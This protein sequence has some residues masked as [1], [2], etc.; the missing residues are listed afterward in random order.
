ME[1]LRSRQAALAAHPLF[2]R[3]DNLTDLRAF[4]EAHVF[5]VWDF[6]SLLKRLQ[7]DLTCVEVPWRPSRHPDELVRFINQIVVGEESDLGPDGEATSH[8][9]LYLEAMREVGANTARIQDFLADLDWSNVPDHVAPFTRHTLDVARHGTTL[10]VAAAF[11]YGREKLIPEMFQGIVNVLKA[12]GLAWP[13]L[14]FYLERHIQVDGEEHGP[15]AERCLEHLC[16]GDAVAYRLAE[17]AGIQALKERAAL[18]DR[19][20]E[21]LSAGAEAALPLDRELAD[22]GQGRQH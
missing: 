21:F 14:L 10:E 9:R 20:L 15:L 3:L 11:F 19:T 6:M 5:A 17:K 22:L 13:K 16:A 18:W 8:F 4:M 1:T 12:E 2:A 7:K